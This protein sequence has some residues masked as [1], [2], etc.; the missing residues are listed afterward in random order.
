MIP[1]VAGD[2]MTKPTSYRPTVRKIRAARDRSE[3]KIGFLTL[4]WRLNASALIAVILSVVTI[5]LQLHGYWRGA[6]TNL[7]SAEKVI[8]R[9][10][11]AG[12]VRIGARMAYTND[13]SQRY[14][15]LI[16]SEK[17]SFV[18]G[19]QE[20]WQWAE[21]RGTFARQGKG[22]V[23]K[24]ER[25]APPFIV[26]AMDLVSHE[27]HFAA[28]ERPERSNPWAD[29]LPKDKFIKMLDEILQKGEGNM[30]ITFYTTAKQISGFNA[31]EETVLSTS[32]TI[33]IDK[34][35]R[36]RMELHGWASRT[37]IH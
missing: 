1:E 34:G 26:P 3:T 8:L 25:D 5:T 11:E 4:D 31:G 18:L 12:A 28:R 24:D 36:D 22:L 30:K 17:L 32:C 9:I 15:A 23:F 6:R 21:N 35:L 13:G 10:S 16:Q 29:W 14:N 19:N 2:R 33:T 7:H 37:C 27:S 20:Y